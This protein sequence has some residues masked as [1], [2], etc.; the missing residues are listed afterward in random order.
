MAA[1]TLEGAQK[2]FLRLADETFARHRQEASAGLEKN[3][4]ELKAMLEPVQTTLKRYEENLSVIEKARS[5]AYGSLQAQLEAVGKGQSEV[6]AE[7]AKL[8]SALRS[9]SKASGSW[10]EEQLKN[11]LEMAGLREGIDFDL[12]LTTGAVDDLKRPDA[13]IRL[14]GGRCLVVDSKC[15]LDHYLTGC[16]AGD[17]VAR[18]ES[19]RAHARATKAHAD[20]LT[21]KAYWDQFDGA[22]EFVVMFV[23]GENFLSAALEH[24]VTLLGWAFDRRILLAGPINLLAIA[25]TVALVWRQEK[26][27]DEAR[28]VARL[29]V[30]LYEALKVMAGHVHTVGRHLDG[31]LDGYNK[32]V[33]SLERNVLPKARR[34]PEMGIAPGD[35][36]MPALTVIETTPRT[37]VAPELVILPPADAAE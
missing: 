4:L 25:K 29:G 31:A 32:F 18:T 15:S 20:G 10:G 5:E 33:G 23:P 30:D 21:R 6:R 16:S 14:P 2:Q 7:A 28:E 22:A 17:D 26:L 34:F 13:I 36:P 37:P 19:M 12:Q 27:A 24:D 9:S 35:K 11:V 3:K 1:S 8:V